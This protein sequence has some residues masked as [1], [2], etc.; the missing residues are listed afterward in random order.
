MIDRKWFTQ[1]LDEIERR[2]QKALADFNALEGAEQF[3]RQAIHEIDQEL[4]IP[5]ESLIPGIAV[6]QKQVG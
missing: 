6:E 3:C 5:L 2:K 1:K 4:G